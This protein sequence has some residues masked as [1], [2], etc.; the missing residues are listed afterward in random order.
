ME[1]PE[2]GDYSNTQLATLL[3]DSYKD[4]ENLRR[5]LAQV[6]KRAEKAERLLLN[7]QTIQQSAADVTASSGPS[8]D[9][10][11]MLMELE[12]RA[13]RA[14]RARDDADGRR[15]AVQENW[16]ALERYMSSVEVRSHDARAHFARIIAGDNAA[17]SLPAPSPYAPPPVRLAPLFVIVL[18]P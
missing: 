3:A 12:D 4:V 13:S 7:F 5:E 15:R 10:A 6:R 1:N 2:D 9:I 18:Q 16:V 11:R 14:E 8:P 17:L